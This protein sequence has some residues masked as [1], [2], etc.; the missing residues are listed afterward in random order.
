VPHAGHKLLLFLNRFLR[1]CLN[2]SGT[3]VPQLWRSAH[4]AIYLRCPPLSSEHSWLSYR[5]FTNVANGLAS[6]GFVAVTRDRL[7]CI[8]PNSISV[9]RIWSYAVLAIVRYGDC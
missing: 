1:L 7:L 5:F 6:S 3:A 4:F 2:V 9:L 8:T